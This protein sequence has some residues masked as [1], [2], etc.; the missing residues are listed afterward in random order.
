MTNDKQP[1]VDK[2]TTPQ[3]SQSAE[4]IHGDMLMSEIIQI[5][6]ETVEVM[7]EYGLHCVGCHFN[8]MDTVEQGCRIHGFSDEQIQLLIKDMNA[9]IRVA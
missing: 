3:K 4:T 1:E 9:V 8:V 2:S 7:M 5:Y 6:P